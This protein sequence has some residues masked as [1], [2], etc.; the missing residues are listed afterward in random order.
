MT[1]KHQRLLRRALHRLLRDTRPDR[2]QL[3]QELAQRIAS[4][5]ESGQVAV[6]ESGRDCDG[7]RYWGD[8]T[9][10]PATLIHFNHHWAQR[11]KWAD[12][13]FHLEIARPSEAAHTQS[14]SRDL[15]LEAFEDGHPHCL[16]D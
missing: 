16:F 13:P 15:T 9:L 8:V 14:G 5:T 10:V 3:K 4:H 7:V 2:L 11:A 1:P 12:G 6:I